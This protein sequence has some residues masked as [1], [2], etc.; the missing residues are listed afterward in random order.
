[1]LISYVGNSDCGGSTAGSVQ[2]PSSSGASGEYVPSLNHSYYPYYPAGGVADGLL[3]QPSFELG[4]GR[5]FV[6]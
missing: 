1:M 3:Q 6:F 5:I 4:E 2:G